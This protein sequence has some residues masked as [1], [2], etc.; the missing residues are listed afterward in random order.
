MILFT[1]GEI[2][3]AIS[4]FSK[5]LRMST[6]LSFHQ[7]NLVLPLLLL[8]LLMLLP[9]HAA[10]T[11]PADLIPL[12]KVLQ[13]AGYQV[14]FE[15]PPVQGAY[16][17]TNVRK[18]IIWV[19][20]ITVELGIVRQT[21][22]HEAVHGAQG[23]PKGKLEVI[24]WKTQMVNAVDREVAGILYRNYAHSKF[25]VEREA[26]SMQGNPQAVELVSAALKQR[27]R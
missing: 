22:I 8:S 5:E 20:P 24:G 17:A 16:G 10:P 9:S 15:N 6:R 3:A 18:K 7:Y 19:A 13:K 2:P 27:C 11:W 1:S 25:D 12:L 26:F 21:L 14:R 4:P 23:C